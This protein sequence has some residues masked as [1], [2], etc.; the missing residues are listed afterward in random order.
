[1]IMFSYVFERFTTREA[2]F[3]VMPFL[4]HLGL[5]DLKRRHNTYIAGSKKQRLDNSKPIPHLELH[6]NTDCWLGSLAGT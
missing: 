6:H 3:L 5:M 1:M 4:K 2:S